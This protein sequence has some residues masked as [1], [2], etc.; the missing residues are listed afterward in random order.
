MDTVLFGI[1]NCDTVKKARSFLEKNNIA[2]RFHD[3]RVD[4]INEALIQQWLQQLPAEQ[5][6][7][8]RSTTW[9]Q[10]DNTAQAAVNNGDIT[11]VCCANPTLIKRPV[12]QL[13]GGL[14]TGFSD[15]QYSA[16]FA[17]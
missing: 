1:K 15:K 5:L 16:L 12:L 11:S 13:N 6:V 4:G 10:L 9:K 14:H 8:K 7:N 17:I 2:Y 3:F